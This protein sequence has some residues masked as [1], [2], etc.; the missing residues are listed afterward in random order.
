MEIK[1]IYRK[2]QFNPG[3]FGVIINPFYFAR[4]GLYESIK[5]LG[6]YITGKTLDI[7]CGKKPYEDLFNS[8]EYIGMDID[9]IGHSHENEKIDVYYDGNIFPFKNNEFDSIVINQ[10][11]EHVFEPDNFIKEVKR[12]LKKNGHL[13][14]TV[15]FIWDEHEK[16]NDYGRYTSF[17]LKYLLKK[18]GFK[19]IKFQKSTCG[20]KAVIQLIN[21]FIVKKVTF[22]SKILSAAVS[23]LLTFPL[24]II[25]ILFLENKKS[26]LYL[27][28]IILAK[29]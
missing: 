24:N 9:N 26:D 12:V 28:N 15:P 17:G 13:L 5:P 23:M 29:K 18:S 3:L 11:L 1:Q 7:G 4:K 20:I 8:S 21:E 2:E 27:D 16:P 25:G 10:V 22:K 6:K 19:I 14:I